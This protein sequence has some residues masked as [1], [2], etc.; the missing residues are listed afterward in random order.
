LETFVAAPVSILDRGGECGAN[1]IAWPSAAPLALPRRRRR[2]GPQVGRPR[3]ISADGG[4][5]VPRPAAALMSNFSCRAACYRAAIW[6]SVW[7]DRGAGFRLRVRVS[8]ALGL[9]PPAT[10]DAERRE[11]R[12]GAPWGCAM[13]CSLF[14][15]RLDR[16]QLLAGMAALLAPPS[17]GCRARQGRCRRRRAA[18]A[19]ALRADPA[20]AGSAAGVNLDSRPLG[21]ERRASCLGV[22]LLCATRAELPRLGSRTL[23]TAPRW[24]GLDRGSLAPTGRG[25]AANRGAPDLEMLRSGRNSRLPP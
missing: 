3:P 21:L 24:L 1:P 18:A 9:L 16:R 17:P 14:V 10:P 25:S 5:M 2:T 7:P 8:L 11:S 4:N 6:R 13:G 23:A 15:S 19:A 20:P 22:R 12:R